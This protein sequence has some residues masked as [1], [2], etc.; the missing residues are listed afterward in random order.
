VQQ[1]EG[2]ITVESEPDC[3]ATFRIL[4]PLLA[5]EQAPPAEEKETSVSGGGKILVVDDEEALCSLLKE[6]L[7]VF[8]YDV[9]TAGDGVEALEVFSTMDPKPDLVILD[10]IMPR[11][12]GEECFKRLRQL[13]PSLRILLSSGFSQDVTMEELL[14]QGAVGLIQKPYR[15]AELNQMVAS[16]L[17][18]SGQ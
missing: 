5:E 8:G 9:E 16:A 14:G 12:D 17:S 18:S 15:A 3:G 6:L 1:H 10:M 2:T 4:L 7:G 11:M 13:D